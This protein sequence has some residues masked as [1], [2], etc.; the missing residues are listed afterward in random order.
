MEILGFVSSLFQSSEHKARFQASRSY[1]YETTS[2]R[3]VVSSSV[4]IADADEL[5][6]DNSWLG[7]IGTTIGTT[8]IRRMNIFAT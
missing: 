4:A 7:N 3:E 6:I 5:K 1:M 8:S 2:E